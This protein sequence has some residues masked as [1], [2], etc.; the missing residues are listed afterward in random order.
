MNSKIISQFSQHAESYD[1]N[2]L[3]QRLAA[4]MLALFIAE[5]LETAQ[6]TSAMMF[7]QFCL[8]PEAEAQQINCRTILEIGSGTGLL[9]ELLLDLFPESLIVCIDG[10]K[11]MLS[12]LKRKLQQRPKQAEIEAYILDC[13][14]LSEFLLPEEA[15]FDLIVSSFTLQ[16]MRDLPLTIRSLTNLLAPGGRLI[17]S[18]PGQ[19][20]F[21]EW[22]EACRIAELPFTGNALPEFS[23]LQEC[24]Q[25]LKL[26]GTIKE[27][28]LTQQFD[29]ARQFFQTLKQTGASERL[30]LDTNA[31]EPTTLSARQMRMLIKTW[32]SLF[33]GRPVEATYQVIS[34]CLSK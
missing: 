5:E 22:K 13:N 11:E 18:V 32:D 1:K 25:Q 30:Y 15:S 24:C 9:T 23:E 31:P 14:R 2:A 19:A 3:V 17:F 7:K 4:Q 26:Q 12:K 34:A 29:S 33:K 16:W 6:H 10:S 8:T 21:R 20:S 27:H 28:D